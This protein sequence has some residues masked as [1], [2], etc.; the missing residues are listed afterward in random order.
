MSFQRNIDQLAVYELLSR[1]Q[2]QEVPR[3]LAYQKSISALE[4]KYYDHIIS[5]ILP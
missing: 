1:N 5:S 3:I 4:E 2:G